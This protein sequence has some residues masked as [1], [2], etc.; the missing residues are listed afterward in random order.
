MIQVRIPLEPSVFYEY[1]SLKI[2]KNSCLASTLYITI[3][4]FVS[5][6][7]LNVEFVPGQSFGGALSRMNIIDFVS[8]LV[9]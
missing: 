5:C 6:S 4:D 9:F 3:I 2:T 7:G 1:L 8:D